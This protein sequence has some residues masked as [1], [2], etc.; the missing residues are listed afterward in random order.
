[1]IDS[2]LVGKI[3]LLKNHI[4]DHPTQNG[5]VQ[6]NYSKVVTFKLNLNKKTK[7]GRNG[8]KKGHLLH[9]QGGESMWTNNHKQ[10]KAVTRVI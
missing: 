6:G 9:S 2:I 4:A 7:S 10:E 8:W 5:S 3:R 1:M